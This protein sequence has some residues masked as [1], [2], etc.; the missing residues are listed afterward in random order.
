M[1]QEGAELYVRRPA[2]CDL[3]CEMVRQCCRSL[4]LQNFSLKFISVGVLETMQENLLENS[5]NSSA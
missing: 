4:D 5:S 1:A 2:F 3:K